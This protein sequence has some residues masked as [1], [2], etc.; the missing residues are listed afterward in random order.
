ME[1]EAKIKQGMYILRSEIEQMLAAR[2]AF[3]KDNLG[4][5]FI[6]SR[7]SKIAE[8]MQGNAERIP[9][10]IEFWLRHIDE[11]FDYYSKPMKFEVPMSA[12]EEF[13]GHTEN[14]T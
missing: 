14:E 6:H 3:L 2:A 12:V 7:A 11:V 1:L 8:I 4:Q 13:L 5:G 9:D 10:L